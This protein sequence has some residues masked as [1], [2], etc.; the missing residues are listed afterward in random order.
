MLKSENENWK[1]EVSEQ[2]FY[3][4]FNKPIYI[5]EE[6]AREIISTRKSITNNTPHYMV[7]NGKGVINVSKA[8][9]DYLSSDDA[10]DG[11]IAGAF[12]VGSPVT[13][14][15]GNFFLLISKPNRPSRLFTQMEDALNW[16]ESFKIANTKEPKAEFDERGSF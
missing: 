15:I 12:L 4:T 7:L 13:K 14:I 11:V 16:I 6:H 1:I 8:A 5:E 2:I 3:L 10:T 9:R